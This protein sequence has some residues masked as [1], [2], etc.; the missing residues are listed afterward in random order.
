M[1]K[2]VISFDYTED[3]VWEYDESNNLVYE[4]LK[5]A[6]ED[7]RV[8]S[9]EKNIYDLYCKHFIFDCNINEI[10]WDVPGIKKDRQKMLDFLKQLKDL[11]NEYNDNNFIIEDYETKKWEELLFE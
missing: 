3:F 8:I 11:L 4:Y 1:N 2:I 5:K 9:A 6:E 10:V 7:Q